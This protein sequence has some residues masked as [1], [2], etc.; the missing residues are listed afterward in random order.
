M[1]GRKSHF[2]DR[3]LCSFGVLIL[4]VSISI[5]AGVPDTLFEQEYHEAFPLEEGDG[6]NDVRA[7]AVDRTGDVWV[8]TRAGVFR[9][10]RSTKQWIGLMDKDN[11]GP[12]YDIVV[13][14]A[15]R[16]WIGAWNGLY[17]S[18]PH[19]LKKLKR[20]D[21]PIA[22]LSVVGG[23]IIGL[24]GG[25]IWRVEGENCA[26]ER[27][28]YSGHYRDVLSDKNG[29]LWIATGMGLYH[30][31]NSGYK[32]YQTQSELLGPDIHGIAYARDGNLW[33]GGLG[34]ITI[35]K[36]SNRVG[37]F[38]PQN[39][40]PSISVQSVVQG[41]DGFMWVGTDRG[42]ARYDGQN[43]S[44]RH[45]RRWLLDDDVRDVAFDSEGTAWIATG[46]GVSAIKRKSMTLA[47]K[48][49]YFLDICL[50]RHVRDPGL[51]EKC[52]LR[53]PGDTNT[54]GPRDDDNDGQYT[55]MYLAMESFRYAATKSPQAKANA[56]KAF[57]ALR[58]LQTVTET[59]GF[60]ARTMIPA[61][62]TKMADPNRKISDRQ[63]AEM[64]ID[65]PREKR[66]ETR[67]RLSRD[68]KWRWKADTSSDEIT[69]HMFGYL[70]YY[71]LVADEQE[72]KHVA[73]H[74]LNIVDYIIEGGYVLRG[75]DGTHTKWGVWAPE[76]LNH[77]PDWAPERG[78]NSVEIL[79]F[80]KLAYHVS[81]DERYQKEYM[82][83][84][85]EHNYAANVRH[86]KT[87]NPTW[88]THIDDEL[89][90][91]AYP[92]LMMH[93]DDPTLRRLYCVSVDHWYDAVKADD[94]PFFEY[95]YGA[96]V[97]QTPQLKVTIE[98][99]RDASLDLVRWTVDNSHREDICIVRTPEWEHLQT[100]RL[101]PLSER[102]VIR[103]DE[104]PR[105][106]IQGDGGHTESD[107]VWWLLP[108]WMGRYYGYIQPP[109]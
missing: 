47:E 25:G 63:W 83:L 34:G 58:F 52:W 10:D 8:G 99:L 51:V 9:L 59:S 84:L 31:T 22:A 97:G 41:S 48:A 56:K 101:L 104:N 107:G 27:T 39:G 53:V 67:W 20:I 28:P 3:G 102:G 36:D 72:K 88:R 108:Y 26:F 7:V 23:T 29:G 19:G 40:L 4:F 18:T 74:I 14:R 61:S 64:V 55:A 93:E 37:Y 65:N 89:L 95:I 24:G 79:S 96:C 82:H 71:D 75:M 91:L 12:V 100:D 38:T 42:I 50:T 70:F 16:F 66:V 21:C 32:L 103:W 98:S 77:D 68:G 45:S 5:G 33:I 80:L 105:R 85:N 109:Q 1:S 94:S 15:G 62:W 76:K 81:G 17:Q 35:Y 49:D 54:W 86:A 69:G 30:H 57:E 6:C 92:C 2:G 46:S 73:R 60:V 13:D 43:W 11:A 106:V 87:T 44:L 90:S 78:I